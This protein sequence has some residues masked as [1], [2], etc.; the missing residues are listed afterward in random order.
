[1]AGIRRLALKYDRSLKTNPLLV[2]CVTSAGIVAASDSVAQYALHLKGR[3]CDEGFSLNAFRSFAIGTIYGGLQ[4]A[5]VLHF[6][7]TSW[8]RVLPSKS[9]PALAFKTIVDM[10]T[11]FPVNLSSMIAL[12]SILRGESADVGDVV[13]SVKKNIWPSIKAGW[14][15]WPVMTVLMYSVVPLHYRVLFLNF[16]SFGWNF[17]M[18]YRF[19]P[20]K[21]QE[22]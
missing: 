2:K 18:V 21:C 20:K 10:T 5:P 17:F 19:T 11:S 9:L 3:K 14:T 22:E 8:E 6:V 13:D 1:M 15:F 4:F 7:T 12:Q 16:G